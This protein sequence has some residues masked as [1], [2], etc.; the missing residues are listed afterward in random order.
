MKG[1]IFPPIFVVNKQSLPVHMIMVY[2]IVSAIFTDEAIALTFE[3]KDDSIV[4]FILVGFVSYFWIKYKQF[5]PKNI[6]VI[7][8]HICFF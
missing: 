8:S 2:Y 4:P 5:I 3:I 7:E 1:K 6:C